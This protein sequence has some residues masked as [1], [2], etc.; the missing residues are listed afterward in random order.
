MEDS[1]G[2]VEVVVVA[3]SRHLALVVV[4]GVNIGQKL[5]VSN[6]RILWG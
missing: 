1:E 3:S 5:G 4:E 2:V 6:F